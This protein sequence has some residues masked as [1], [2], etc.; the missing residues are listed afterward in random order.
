MSE[1]L[2]SPQVWVNGDFIPQDELYNTTST[3]DFNSNFSS[4]SSPLINSTV[5]D[6][7]TF[8]TFANVDVSLD[9]LMPTIEP[10]DRSLSMTSQ[11]DL[12]LRNGLFPLEMSYYHPSS[13]ASPRQLAMPE[14]FQSQTST[15]R[16]SELPRSTRTK[17]QRDRSQR[18]TTVGSDSSSS[19]DSDEERLAE[20]RRKNKLAARRL[21]QKKL[22]QVSELEAQ[23]EEMK[24]ERDLLRLRA[25]KS[26]G[27]VMALRQMLDQKVGV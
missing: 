14:Q 22:D 18:Q 6:N 19:Q 3:C 21:R 12:A 5:A 2:E 15:S 23:L 25:A 7:G 8:N 27:E 13:S 17:T 10:N 11:K 24:K 20:K 16:Q 26:E 9:T 1:L 4:T